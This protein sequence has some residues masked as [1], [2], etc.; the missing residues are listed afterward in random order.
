MSEL[1]NIIIA[2]DGTGETANTVLQAALVQYK[3]IP[4]KKTR[5]IKIRTL[6]QIPPLIKEAK[7]KKAIL[8]Y[9]I[10]HEKLKNEL[11]FQADQNKIPFVDILGPIFDELDSFLGKG[12][13]GGRRQAGLYHSLNKKYFQRVE[14]IEYTVKHDDG[15]VLDDLERADLLLV[16]I[17]RT[18]K[19]PLSIFLSHK[20]WKVV[21]I[22][23]VLGVPLPKEIFEV[24]Q[25]K[26][27]G[28]TIS[29]E[30]LYR[31]RKKRLEKFG[32]PQK[33]GDYAS[34]KH[35]EEELSYAEGL[36]KK[37]RQWP[38]FDITDKALEETAFEIMKVISKRMGTPL[39]ESF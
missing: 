10:A 2:S 39:E 8:F 21:N 26:I 35:I 15:K 5:H 14:A 23:I 16:G 25:K 12:D 22:P 32:S 24:N 30:K 33:G 13:K 9:T 6:D 36:F 19:T 20:G 28:L 17:S 3:G 11:T 18:S 37:N 34:L 38:I 7:Q 1:K 4:V 31:I 27:V 29:M